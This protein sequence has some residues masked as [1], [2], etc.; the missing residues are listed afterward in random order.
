LFLSLGF[1]LLPGLFKYGSGEKI[2][3]SGKV[4]AWLDA[5]LP[6]SSPGEAMAGSDGTA[7]RDGGK[8]TAQLRWLD[9]L[10][11]GLRQARQQDR[12][13]FVD[14]TGYGCLNCKINEKEVFPKPTIQQLFSQ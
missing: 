12:L 3:P 1:Y 5:I 13:V 9:N 14:F 8:G 11:E 2:R 6:P 10:E 4:F 7:P